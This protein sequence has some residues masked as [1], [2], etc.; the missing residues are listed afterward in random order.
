MILSMELLTHLNACEEGIL[1]GKKLNVIGLNTDDAI[2]ILRENGYENYAEW[3][4]S[5]IKS[6]E[7]LEFDSDSKIIYLILDPINKIYKSTDDLLIAKNIKDDLIKT[8][9]EYSNLV[10]IQEEIVAW[11]GKTYR[12]II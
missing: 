3:V 2:M 9:G 1:V 5:V 4:A 6:K 10:T 8:S 7:A 12:F 11:D